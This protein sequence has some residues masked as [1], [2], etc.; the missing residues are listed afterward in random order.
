MPRDL[1]TPRHLR[2]V[3]ISL[4]EA[5]GRVSSFYGIAPREWHLRFPYELA[6]LEGRREP[7]FEPGALAR[8]LRER[9]GEGGRRSRFRIVLHDSEILRTGRRHGLRRT[10]LWVLTHELIHVVRFAQRPARYRARGT[11]RIEEEARV[12]E[13]SRKVLAPAGDE[14]LEALLERMALLSRARRAEEPPAPPPRSARV[15]SP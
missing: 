3:A 4:E 8:V 14:R 7:G 15:G 5:E 12:L 2:I 1:F 10:L 11:A 9:P 13:L 6:T